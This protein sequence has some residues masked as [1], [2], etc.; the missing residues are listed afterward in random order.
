M[1]ASQGAPSSPPAWAYEDR[2]QAVMA[3]YWT[4]TA[5]A[6]VFVLARLYART[7]LRS[8]GTDDL[9]MLISLVSLRRTWTSLCKSD[10]SCRQPSWL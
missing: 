6:L 1:S 8:L 5:I 9:F 3:I 10:R 2:G 7:T 4:E